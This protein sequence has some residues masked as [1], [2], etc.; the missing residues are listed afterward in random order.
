MQPTDIE[1]KQMTNP[2]TTIY[3]DHPVQIVA[4]AINLAGEETRWW[5][6]LFNYITFGPNRMREY[7]AR[8]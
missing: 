8:R 1:T 7:H 6:K 4:S 3:V 2:T 5:M